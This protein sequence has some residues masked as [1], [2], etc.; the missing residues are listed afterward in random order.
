MSHY[1]S[2][3]VEARVV[4]STLVE[5]SDTVVCFLECQD[6]SGSQR[7]MQNPDTD[8]QVV[9]LG[10]VEITMGSLHM[11]VTRIRHVLA[12][13]L[14]DETQVRTCSIQVQKLPNKAT[15]NA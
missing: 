2:H 13:L 3:T 15:I 12:Q 1:S 7:N 10:I 9:T 6:I 5:K 14:H 8:L 11:S 4:Y